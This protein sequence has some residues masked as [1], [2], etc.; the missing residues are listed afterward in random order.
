MT[1]PIHFET[2]LPSIL[3]TTVDAFK[4]GAKDI[5]NNLLMTLIFSLKQ[6]NNE[7][8]DTIFE[9]EQ[10]PQLSLTL[11]TDDFQD[12]MVNLEDMIEKLLSVSKVCD[13]FFSNIIVLGN[14]VSAV[15]SELRHKE[16]KIAS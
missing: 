13:D 1:M 16:Q 7:F 15:A 10:N 4:S 6:Q 5:A 9:L 3:D 12:I 8:K 11:D 2:L 14:E